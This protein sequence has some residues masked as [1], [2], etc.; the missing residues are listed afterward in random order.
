[1]SSVTMRLSQITK[2]GKYLSVRNLK[3]VKREDGKTLHDTENIAASLVGMTVDYLTRYMLGG[4]KTDAFQISLEGATIL[5]LVKNVSHYQLE[6]HTLLDEISGLD[7]LSII[8]ACKLTGFDV[9]Q[10]SGLSGYK[11]I[12]DIHPDEDT[13][14]NIRIMVER[15]IAFL[16]EYGPVIK[17]GF[18][19]EGGYTRT[20]SKG[21]G[22]YLTSD[23]LWDFKVSVSNPTS[24]QVLQILVYYLMGKH[25][26]HKEFDSIKKIGLYNPRKNVIRYIDIDDIPKETMEAVC[27]EVIGYQLS[28]LKLEE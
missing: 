18:T 11:P 9:V 16:E 13:I 10:R 21:D 27:L 12:E 26:I 5:D 19:F 3:T 22:D 23:A 15:S 24:K 25:S 8:N 28:D 1:M 7:D 2:H 4:E 14:V 20:I 6:A 17:E